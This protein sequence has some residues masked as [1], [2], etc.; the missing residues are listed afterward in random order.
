MKRT[1]LLSLLIAATVLLSG[2]NY[3][4]ELKNLQLIY[5]TALDLNEKNEI[6]TTVTIQSPGS[7]E[8]TAPTHEVITASGPTMEEALYQKVGTQLAGPIGTSKNQVMLIS[9]KLARTDLASLLD[10]TF[11][12]SSDPMLSMVAIVRGKASSLIDLER[13]GSATAGEYLRKLIISARYETSIPN[14]TLHKIFP[15][16]YDP[17]RDS[18]L[19]IL[20]RV[21]NRAEIDGIALMN[22]RRFTGYS[23]NPDQSTLLLL[24]EGKLGGTCVITRNISNDGMGKN[25][26]NSE[27]DADSENEGKMNVENHSQYASINVVSMNRSK[28]V[29][30]ENSRKVHVRIRLQLEA[31]LIEYGKNSMAD[32]QT[33][34]DLENRLSAMLTAEAKQATGMLKQANSDPLG[35]GRDLM[36]FHRGTWNKMDWNTVY[37][38]TEFEPI[39][40]VKIVSKGIKN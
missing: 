30:L 35:I 7:K 24:L 11:R 37:P 6:V 20:K 18:A 33:I 1:A 16:F 27:N 31:A 36:A 25:E 40:K 10:A 3:H 26:G 39:I 34:D 13:I 14:V 38:Q 28:K 15:I 29:W 21:G 19:P 8:R 22:N 23:L 5:A 32:K 4:N 2:C 9:D 12:S 17:G